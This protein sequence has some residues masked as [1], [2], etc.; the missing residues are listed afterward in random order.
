ML[1]PS[2]KFIGVETLKS[3]NP[4]TAHRRKERDAEKKKN[5]AE[6]KITREQA[7]LKKNPVAIKEEL[8][9]LEALAK[10][11]QPM[12]DGRT[13]RLQKLQQLWAQVVSSVEAERRVQTADVSS[14][15]SGDTRSSSSTTLPY[16]KCLQ[17][18]LSHGERIPDEEERRYYCPELCNTGIFRH[19]DGSIRPYPPLVANDNA[20]TQQQ[21]LSPSVPFFTAPFPVAPVAPCTAAGA[22]Q[23]SGGPYNGGSQRPPAFLPPGF[24]VRLHRH[25]MS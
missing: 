10:A 20:A 13:R 17:Q 4:S 18:R 22:P 5:K 1:N 12:S 15:A 21:H 8:D 7:L 11:G 25:S 3:Y 14:I 16:A 2:K 24:T 6:R 19:P 23:P 9:K